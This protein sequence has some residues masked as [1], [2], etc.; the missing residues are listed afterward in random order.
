MCTCWAWRAG[1]VEHAVLLG[2]PVSARSQRWAMARRAVAGRLIN[3][4]T[5]RDWVL[6]AVYRASSGFAC[7][8]AGLVPVPCPGVEN[9][10]LTALV[11]GH[12][13]YM[14][15]MNEILDVLQMYN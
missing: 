9:V 7:H 10:N 14:P 15:H 12:L 6:A 13:S 3:G 1:I 11:D 2:M 8:A 4:Y 5:Q